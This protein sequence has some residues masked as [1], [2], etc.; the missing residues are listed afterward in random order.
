MPLLYRLD[1]IPR[2][3]VAVDVVVVVIPRDLAIEEGEAARKSA[4][5]LEGRLRQKLQEV[6][7]REVGKS[8]EWFALLPCT[9]PIVN[10]QHQRFNFPT[11]RV[12]SRCP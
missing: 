2:A 3:Y 6:A 7:K 10:V 4:K 12:Q 9:R 11:F 1:P 8:I 5:D